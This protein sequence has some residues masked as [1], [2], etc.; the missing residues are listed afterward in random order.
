[1]LS[2]AIFSAILLVFAFPFFN[3]FPLAWVGLLPLLYALE[4]RNLRQA[5]GT[6]Y[7]FGLHF[8]ALL[9]YSI[10]S[11]TF[12][13]Y[14]LLIAYLALFYA[15]FA[16]FTVA[17]RKYTTI[18]LFLAVPI[19]WTFMEE[20]MSWGFFGVTLPHLTYSQT[21]FLPIIQIAAITGP[22]GIAFILLLV[23][24]LV[25]ESLIVP[26]W[27]QKLIYLGSVAIIIAGIFFIGRAVIPPLPEKNEK[28]EG[29]I[30]VAIVQGNIDQDIKWD[31]AYKDQ[32]YNKYISLSMVANHLKPDIIIW[33]E[34]SIPFHLGDNPSDLQRIQDFCHN[35]NTY[36]LA[37]IP[38][39]RFNDDS[40]DTQNSVVLFSPAGELVAKYD[41]MKLVPFS[42]HVPFGDDIPILQSIME[43]AGH[44]APGDKTVIFQFPQGKFG[45]L[46]CFESIF[47]SIARELIAEGAEFLVI[48][49]NDAWFGT[50][51]LIH[52]HAAE[53]ILRA[54]ENRTWVVRAANTGI[55]EVIDPYGRVIEKRGVKTSATINATIYPRQEESFYTKYYWLFP[56]L[57]LLCGGALFILI[58]IGMVKEYKSH[59][60]K[61]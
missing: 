3:L 9:L 17:T 23:N 26:S 13:G 12:Y 27:K 55:S 21:T 15:L 58:I 40:V 47:P 34:T 51:T 1:M 49:T 57:I 28:L 5:F 25:Y 54:V 19:L 44:F 56:G 52:Q 16:L 4:N 46:I 45:A 30:E 53:A 43:E 48:M 11:I 6:G 31:S 24:G 14:F 39:R 42:E 60:G 50:S 37:G 18:P 29:A 38:S 61:R 35:V 36:L 32:V 10:I 2:Y 33:P 59:P 22:G 8:S 41:K 20:V 7:V